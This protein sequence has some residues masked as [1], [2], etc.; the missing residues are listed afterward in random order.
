M[1]K[2]DSCQ[3][4]EELLT[5]YL[6]AELTQ[7]ES[8]RVAVHI[9]ECPQCRQTY[10]Q[11]KQLQHAV[12]D[13]HYPNMEQDAL[14]KIVNDMTSKTIQGVAWFSLSAGLTMIIAMAVYA[15]WVDTG[16]SWYE[17][18]AM[19]LIWGGGIG[20]FISVLRQRLISRKTDKYRRVKL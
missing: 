12:Q 4:V 11:L 17:K 15:F 3:Q 5:G 14:E 10:Q 16:M 8:Q 7:Q 20:L 6:D 2:F 19:S 13:A 18:L 1:S 9:E